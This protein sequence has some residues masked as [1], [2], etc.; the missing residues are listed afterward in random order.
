M[1]KYPAHGLEV[2]LV[3]TVEDV[4]GDGEGPRQILGRLGLSCSGGAGGG[5]SQEELQSHGQ[6]DVAAVR[7]GRDHQASCVTHPLVKVFA[8]EIANLDIDVVVGLVPPFMS[9]R[10]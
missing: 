8:L 5:P 2:H 7:Q 1:K 3:A 4:A 10:M 6:R 9:A